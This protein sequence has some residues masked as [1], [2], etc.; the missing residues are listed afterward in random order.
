M[1]LTVE[2]VHL[3]DKQ[4]GKEVRAY[5]DTLT[6]P[7]GSLGRLEDLAVQLAEITSNP[8]PV[9]TPPGVIVFAADHGVTAEGVS[10]FPKEVT[11]QM[12]D[13][14]LADGSAINVLSKMIAARFNIVD[15]GVADD[16]EG[17]AL[18]RR[19]VRY[20]TANFCLHDAMS[21]KEAIEAVEAGIEESEYMIEKDGI[22]C[23]IPGDMGIGNTTASSAILAVLSNQPLESL[24]GPGTGISTKQI[25]QKQGIIAKALASRNPDPNDPIDILSKVG[26]LEIAGIVG[27]VL[28]AAGHRI[29]VVIDGFISTVAALLAVKI[30]PEAA[31]YMIIGHRSAEPGHDAS[32]TMLKKEPLLDLRL[33]LGEGSGAALAFPI[34]EASTKL[35]KDM[36]TFDSSGI[37]EQN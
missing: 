12:V 37:F 10:A 16:L 20:G 23:L 26:G 34:L 3:T 17:S 11:A 13:N 28:S 36:A 24:V 19:K 2:R 21:R 27:A 15:V 33:R 25:K 29:P 18:I 1:N 4:M 22:K 6:K 8:F 30:A 7:P 14:F 31:D 32:I 5:L 35:L 9:V